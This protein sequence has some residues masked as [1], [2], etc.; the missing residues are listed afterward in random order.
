MSA[1]S[2]EANTA[3]VLPGFKLANDVIMPEVE[4]RLIA[5][6]ESCNP[7]HYPGDELGGLRAISFGW[8]YDLGSAAFSPCDPI[9]DEFA[10]VRDIAARFAGLAPED[11]VQCLLNRYEKGAEIPWHCDKPI[12]ED[13]VGISLGA[14]ATMQ[15]RKPLN[16]GYQYGEAKLAPRS[17]YL[18]S[19]EVRKLFDHSIPSVKGTRWSITF[20]TLSDEGRGQ[21]A[22]LAASK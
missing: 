18:L 9:P 17:M 4:A 16:G 8:K 5:L 12:W 6:V 7:Q 20:R 15:F 14:Q 11:F 13:V 2:D 3:G 19:G 10:F 21:A 1:R 22:A